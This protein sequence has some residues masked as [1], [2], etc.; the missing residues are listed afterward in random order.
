MTKRIFSSLAVL[1]VGLFV[2]MTTVTQVQAQESIENNTDTSLEFLMEHYLHEG[3]IRHE[4]FSLRNNALET[5]LRVGAG[6]NVAFENDSYATSEVD[7]RSIVSHPCFT[8]VNAEIEE[9][10]ERFGSLYSLRSAIMNNDFFEDVLLLDPDISLEVLTLFEQMRTDII[11]NA[12]ETE[13]PEELN[14][15]DTGTLTIDGTT[16]TYPTIIFSQESIDGNDDLDHTRQEIIRMR[17]EFVWE[18]CRSKYALHGDAASCYVRNQ[19][20]VHAKDDGIF[21]DAS[22]AVEYIR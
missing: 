11:A 20:L 8:P 21:I 1:T 2:A 7:L 18:V 3:D 9:C 22:R 4:P 17:S 12:V 14:F 5:F 15:L 6:G 10:M 13:A 16:Y 19:R